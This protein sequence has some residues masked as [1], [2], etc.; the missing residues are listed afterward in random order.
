[1]YPLPIVETS[2]YSNGDLYAKIPGADTVGRVAQ[3]EVAVFRLQRR[4]GSFRG[5]VVLAMEA[6]SYKAMTRVRTPL[7]GQ[8]ARYR[9]LL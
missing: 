7:A 3:V 2:T 6:D 1:M 9:W 8:K 4:P 5:G